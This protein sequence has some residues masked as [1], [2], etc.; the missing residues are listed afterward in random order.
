MV[1]HKAAAP[2]VAHLKGIKEKQNA[3]QQRRKKREDIKPLMEA[4]G[5]SSL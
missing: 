3:D 4:V 2:V 5:H 1:V